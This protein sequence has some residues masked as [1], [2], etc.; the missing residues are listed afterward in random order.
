M[1]GF[2][3]TLPAPNRR[4]LRIGLVLELL[5]NGICHGLKLGRPSKFSIEVILSPVI[6]ASLKT[7]SAS[8]V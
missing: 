2:G 1:S 8:D 5:G 4:I 6:E 7:D 3:P